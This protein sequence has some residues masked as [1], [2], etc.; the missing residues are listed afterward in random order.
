MMTHIF[1]KKRKKEI[2]YK[3]IINIGLKKQNKKL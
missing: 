1:E 2:I 3:F